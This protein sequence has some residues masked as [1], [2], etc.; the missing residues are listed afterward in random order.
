MPQMATA[1]HCVRFAVVN[2]AQ[3][4]KRLALPRPPMGALSGIVSGAPPLAFIPLSEVAPTPPESRARW[5]RWTG[6]IV[7]GCQIGR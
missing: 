1:A 7:I 6:R 3:R 4:V 2:T 5:C